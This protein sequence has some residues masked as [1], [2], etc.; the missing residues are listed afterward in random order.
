MA[1]GSQNIGNNT[2]VFG[3]TQVSD[4]VCLAFSATWLCFS[5]LIRT[6]QNEAS[7]S[8]VHCFSSRY[9]WKIT[10][11]KSLSCFLSLTTDIISL[12]IYRITG[13]LRLEVTSGD[14]LVLSHLK[15]KSSWLLSTFVERDSTTSL[16][17]LHSKK[18]IFLHLNGFSCISISVHFL[19]PFHYSVS[20]VIPLFPVFGLIHLNAN[21]IILC[22]RNRTVLWSSLTLYKVTQNHRMAVVGR[23]LCGSSSPTPLLK[24]GHLEQVA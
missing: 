6:Q 24:Q 13:W 14:N 18:N 8:F 22:W 20:L 7:I 23:E 2:R 5:D 15:T 4:K 16:H 21:H 1:H 17:Q 12:P 9:S 3:N 19:L 11:G 10:R